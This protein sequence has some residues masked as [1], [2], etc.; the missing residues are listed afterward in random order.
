MY[1]PHGSDRA[2]IR[3]AP[4]L[5]KVARARKNLGEF[6]GHT[7]IY[8]GLVDEHLAKG[9]MDSDMCTAF[10]TMLRRCN[11]QT[12]VWRGCQPHLTQRSNQ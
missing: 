12:G 9:W 7:K 6:M 4:F 1:R 5:S 8:D 11:W 10:V 2:E 3:G